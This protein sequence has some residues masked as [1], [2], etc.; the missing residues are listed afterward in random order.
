[1][2]TF[3]PALSRK[4]VKVDK[5]RGIDKSRLVKKKRLK[6]HRHIEL[7]AVLDRDV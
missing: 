3:A 4:A 6:V 2:T 5:K 1:M 7:T